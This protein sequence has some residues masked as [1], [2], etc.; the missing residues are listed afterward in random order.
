MI[1]VM[2]IIII[3]I[4][5]MIIIIN[6]LMIM[7]M[8]MIIIIIMIMIMTMIMMKKECLSQKRLKSLNFDPAFASGASCFSNWKSRN[9]NTVSEA[10][11]VSVQLFLG[12]SAY[13]HIWTLVFE[14]SAI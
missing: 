7:I 3:M 14:V 2:I 13:H 1:I 10:N 8:I 4:M 11:N 9:L 12:I 5:I 6:L